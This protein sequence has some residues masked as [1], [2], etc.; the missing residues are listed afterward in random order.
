TFTYTITSNTGGTATPTTAQG[1]VTLNFTNR[2]CYVD[3]TNAGT[4]D[5]RSNTP[6]ATLVA[7]QTAS[8]TG[9]TIFIYTGTGTTGQN[10]GI[11]LKANQQL[12]GQGVALVVNANTL[13]AAGTNPT[14]TNTAGDGVT[15]NNGN[16]LKGFTVTGTSVN[17]IAGTTTNGLTVDTVTATAAG[18][19]SSALVLTTPSNNI[20]ITNTTL[21]N[22]PFCLTINGGTA[23]FVM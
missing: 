9:E 21:S 4:A 19:A 16:T 6:F 15:L 1:T 22:S 3:N 8:A 18:A 12:I 23:N 20:T 2:V 14:I 17:G 11:T 5:V 13:L 7:A 10:A